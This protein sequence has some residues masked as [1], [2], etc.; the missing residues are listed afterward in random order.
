M[1]SLHRGSGLV[2]IVFLLVLCS[3][4]W[5]GSQSKGLFGEW[6]MKLDFDNSQMKSILTFARDKE[7]ELTAQWISIF[8]I[9][10]VKDIKREGKN[11]TFTLTNDMGD[12]VYIGNYIGTLEKG[13]LSGLLSSDSGEITTEGKRL[14]RMHPILGSWNMTIKMGDREF[15]TVLVVTPDKQKKLQ[16]EWQSQWGE[17]EITD[18]QFKDGKLTFSRISKFGDREWETTYEGSLKGHTLTG[19]FSSQQGQIPANGKRVGAALVGKWDLTMSSEQGTRKQRLTVLPNLSARF[20]ALSI[21]KIG[22]EE[23]Q[24]SFEMTLQFGDN[25]YEISFG[26]KLDAGKLTGKLT[27]SQG[28]SEVTGTKIKPIRQKK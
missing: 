14:K 22:L 17:H 16:A 18:V 9:G 19:T 2:S 23:G 20:G 10:E 3:G 4:L 28:I 7:G 25:E 5:A 21:K 26:G 24:V 27:T 6:D 11:I 12:Q 13:V 15:K 1:K 8:G